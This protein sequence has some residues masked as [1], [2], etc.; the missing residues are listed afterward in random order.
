MKSLLAGLA[1]ILGSPAFAGDVERIQH[2]EAGYTGAAR[3]D[4]PAGTRLRVDKLPYEVLLESYEGE[5]RNGVASG[6]GAL[7]G[8]ALPLPALASPPVEPNAAAAESGQASAIVDRVKGNAA[9]IANNP[10]AKLL[11]LA[12]AP[13]TAVVFRGA[14]E[15][16]MA[17]GP[18][19]IEAAHRRFQ[20][21][22]LRW[23]PEGLA[24]HFSEQMPVLAETFRGGVPGDGPVVINQY[25]A[26]I[27]SPS[28]TFVGV[29]SGG[30]VSGDWFES[31]WSTKAPD[32]DRFVIGEK[33]RVVNADGRRADC[34]YDAAWLKEPAATDLALIRGDLQTRQLA[35]T[36]P[37]YLRN[38]VRC[39]A[40]EPNGWTYT[41]GVTGS[42]PLDQKH[43]PPYSCADAAGHAGTLTVGKEDAFQC[44]V[45]FVTVTTKYRWGSKVGRALEEA[46][47][48]VRDAI[49]N[50]IEKVGKNVIE[51]HIC[52][53]AQKTPGKDCHISISGGVSFGIPDTKAKKDARA[54]EDLDRF[55]AARK[56]LLEGDQTLM[57]FWRSAALAY[58]A[59]AQSCDGPGQAYSRLSITQM[60]QVLS[61]GFNEDV[62]QRQIASLGERFWD[63]LDKFMPW[64]E[65]GATWRVTGQITSELEAAKAYGEVLKESKNENQRLAGGIFFDYA[66]TLL[67]THGVH[68]ILLAT[69]D[70]AALSKEFLLHAIPGTTLIQQATL[71][72]AFGVKQL[73]FFDSYRQIESSRQLVRKLIDQKLKQLRLPPMPAPPAQAAKE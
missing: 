41:F 53:V 8:R 73:E 57:P 58:E 20:G 36:D 67:V 68:S 31:A 19:E 29:V 56:K 65:V 35:V 61:S 38:P 60:A 48:D 15:D 34:T 7:K 47:R 37:M 5:W 3:V 71:I 33:S 44:S 55:M 45:S 16:G 50:P 43:V 72:N 66:R 17:S 42:S 13:G 32:Y 25:P 59:C 69:S 51:E 24:I 4:F 11:G 14:F 49:L 22:F 2:P 18:G 46:A 30:K 27:T 1:F 9:L 64:L 23:L 70:T 63:S 52:G 54:K 10:S 62:K 21:Q 26:G 39:T 28:R 40:T 6:K 12:P